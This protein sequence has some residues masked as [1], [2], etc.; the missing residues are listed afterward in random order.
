MVFQV[1]LVSYWEVIVGFRYGRGFG[2]DVGRKIFGGRLLILLG[3][4]YLVLLC[5][6]G[7]DCLFMWIVR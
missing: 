4:G 2:L 3:G 7:E 1:D 5:W 6:G